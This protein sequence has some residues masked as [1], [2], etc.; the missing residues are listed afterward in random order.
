METRRLGRTDHRSTVAIFGAAAFWSVTQDEADAAMEQ[1]LAAGV[2]HIDVAPSYGVAEERLGPWMP[3]HRD[4]FFLGCKTLER[5]ADAARAE[6]EASLQ[7]LRTSYFDLYQLH[8]VTTFAELDRATRPGGAL[9]AI[10]RAREEGLVRHIGLTTHGLQ[11]PSVALEAL[12][13]FDFDTVM[14]PL[15]PVMMAHAEYR[16]SM[17][18]LLRVCQEKDVG[19]MAIK[20]VARRPWGQRPRRYNTWYEPLDTLPEIQ[21]AVNFALSYPITAVVTPGDITLLPLVL[22]ACEHVTPLSE[23]ERAALIAAA[24]PADVIF[25]A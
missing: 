25:E 21:R 22:E 3:S 12:R 10:V 7:R 17:E 11:A 13:R 2:N 4:R 16:A 18:A 6:L 20:T 5:D 9:E 19:V 14:L 1:V 15:N 24:S 23:G 8:A